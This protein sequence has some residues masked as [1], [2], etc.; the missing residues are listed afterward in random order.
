M[1]GASRPPWARATPARPA[2]REASFVLLKPRSERKQG[3]DGIIEE[4]RPKVATVSG[5]RVF[6]QN[7]PSVSIGGQVT[8]SPYQLTLQGSGPRRTRLARVTEQL[9]AKVKTL[10]GLIDVTTDLQNKNPQLAVT[11]DR[12]KASALGL[13]ASQVEDAA[14][15][16]IRHNAQV[17]T[18]YTSTNEYQVILELLE[19]YQTNPAS[20]SLLYVR[21]TAG[22]WCRSR[23]SP[24]VRR[25]RRAAGREPPRAGPVLDGSRST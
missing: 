14:Q 23:R 11:I 15:Q 4:L 24:R 20:L 21:N 3:V 1:C 17:S 8:R 13:T 5:I 9:E 6:L 19:Q 16:R 2:T 25:E 18:I 10:P 7:P 22:T 12:D